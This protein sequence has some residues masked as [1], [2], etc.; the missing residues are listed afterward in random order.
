MVKSV[1]RVLGKP[2]SLIRHIEDRPGHDRRYSMDASKI[3]AE[4]DWQAEVE[5]ER[6]IE[7]TVQWYIDNRDWL[8]SVIT[9]EYRNYYSAW[10]SGGR[11]TG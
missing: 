8:E 11:T 6:G 3:R 2:E 10:Y 4:L 9:G 7:N 1:L 5:F